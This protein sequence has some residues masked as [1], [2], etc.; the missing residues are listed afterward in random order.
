MNFSVVIITKDRPLHIRKC[1][2][3]LFAQNDITYDVLVIDSSHN[4][5][6]KNIV[7]EFQT[8][9][10]GFNINHF[11]LLKKGYSAARNFGFSKSRGKWVVFVDD[12]CVLSKNW[13]IEL[14]NSAH[15]LKNNVVAVLGRTKNLYQKN[16][17]SCVSQYDNDYWVS[18]NIDKN[19][20]VK[21]KKILDN[22]NIV[23]NKKIIVENNLNF[24]E[25]LLYGG[26]DLDMGLN[27]NK[28]SFKAI[29]C[30]NLFIYHEWPTNALAFFKRQL[31]YKK[32]Q[33]S[34]GLDKSKL[35]WLNNDFRKV[36]IKS[37]KEHNKRNLSFY[38]KLLFELIIILRSILF[39]LV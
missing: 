39:K 6:T 12:D 28:L 20:E 7:K 4:N 38:Q 35:N 22:R 1:L 37:L 2:N 30:P 27:L 32:S 9:Y 33:D 10:Q 24:D 8:K 25:K 14:N 21:N 11:F 19:F 13:S 36:K 15:L 16:V 26:E 17:F 34:L 29:Y 3:S 31:I 23:Y 18:A 5:F